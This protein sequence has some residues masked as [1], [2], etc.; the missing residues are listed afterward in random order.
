MDWVASWKQIVNDR[1]SLAGTHADP[2]YW[3]R[4]SAS[5]ARSTRMR[6]DEFLKVL[7]PYVSSSKTLIDVGAGAG[8]HAAPLAEKLEWVTA[9]EPSE[10]M[11]SRIPVRDN[12]T[13]VASTWED[14]AVA[15][16]DLVICCHV[17]YGVAD[18]EPFV[19]KLDRS[20]RERVFIM[21]RETD[22]PHPA[23]AIRRR[24]KGEAGPRMPRF[25]DLFML[26]IQMGMAPDVNFLRYPSV[27]RY[28]NLEEALVDTRAMVGDGWDEA[29]GRPMLEE[30]LTPDGDELVFDGG[31]VLSGVAHWQ[32][33]AQT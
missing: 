10:G 21:L 8:R 31:S 27:N 16:A 1:A 26:L 20:A 25:S 11:R 30:L 5:F 2:G 17:L 19:T 23:A 6:V 3:D 13:V 28:A 24:L 18:P 32:P 9:V 7:D 4:R 22:L 14:A 29:I 15:H 33:Q 12:M